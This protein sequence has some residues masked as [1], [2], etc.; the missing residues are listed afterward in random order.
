MDT[1]RNHEC[2]HASG[3]NV[4]GVLCLLV[5]QQTHHQMTLL[6]GLARIKLTS[7]SWTMT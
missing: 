2:S 4:N 7:L 1:E 5:T 6:W 3:Q